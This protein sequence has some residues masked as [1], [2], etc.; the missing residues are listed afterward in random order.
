VGENPTSAEG[1]AGAGGSSLN[2][3]KTAT[4]GEATGASGKKAKQ[5]KIDTSSK[6]L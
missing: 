4:S 1:E 2:E 6:N 5:A 3:G